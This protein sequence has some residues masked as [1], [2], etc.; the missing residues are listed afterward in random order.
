[1]KNYFKLLLCTLTMILSLFSFFITGQPRIVYI[2]K[3]TTV[4]NT[5]KI[6]STKK[7][8][9]PITSI[10]KDNSRLGTYGRL[11]VSNHDVALYDYNVNTRSSLSLQKLVDNKDSAAYYTTHGK[12][13]IA[14]HDYQ[15][16]KVLVNLSVGTKAYIKLS[17]GSIKTYKLIKKSKGKNTGPDLVDTNGNSFF[18]MK[19]DLIMYTCYNGGIMSTLWV[20]A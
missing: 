11:Y 2:K 13:I 1:M 10:K 14:D 6:T 17:D 4:K 15:G 16:F 7:S 18:D 19:S 3:T 20:L 8:I 9:D 12:Y 5:K